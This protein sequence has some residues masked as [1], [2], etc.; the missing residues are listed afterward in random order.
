M[1]RDPRAQNTIKGVTVYTRKVK[2]FGY[3]L[4]SPRSGLSAPNALGL[5]P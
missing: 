2:K 1:I 4:P 3:R 5:R